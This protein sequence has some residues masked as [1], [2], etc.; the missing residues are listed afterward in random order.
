MIRK[1]KN[2]IRLAK[3]CS[4]L[5]L[6]DQLA[7]ARQAGMD[8][9]DWPVSIAS[10]EKITDDAACELADATVRINVGAI[11]TACSTVDVDVASEQITGALRAAN[12]LGATRL[13]L[14]LPSLTSSTNRD[15]TVVDG[16]SRVLEASNFAYAL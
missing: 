11:S 10:L 5:A 16:F 13:N 15:D 7:Q 3:H 8:G 6:T 2:F 4:S 12:A 1:R 9:V 14:T